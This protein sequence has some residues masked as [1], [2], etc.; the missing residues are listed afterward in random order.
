[1]RN[2]GSQLDLPG[3]EG[4]GAPEPA[5]GPSLPDWGRLVLG[6]VWRRKALA[7][8]VFLLGVTASAVYYWL[9]TPLY[10]VETKILAQRQQTLPSI[11]RPGG[12]DEA[13]TRSAHELVHR[14]ENLIN[15]VKQTNLFVG[16]GTATSKSWLE[17][18]TSPST[19]PSRE[20]EDPLNAL[21]LELDRA[22]VVTT[23]EGVITIEIDWPDPQQAYHLLQTAQ[24]NFL[25]ARHLQEITV[26]DDVISLLRGRAATLAADLQK[27]IEEVQLGVVRGGDGSP[28]SAAPRAGTSEDLAQLRA[29]IDAKERAILDVEEF[30][31]RRLAD[32]QAQLDEKRGVYSDAY[33]SV[34]SLRQDIEALTGESPQAAR[35]REDERKLR[36]EYAA[37]LGEAGQLRAPA[38]LAP[39]PRRGTDAS[40]EQNERVREAR[41][42]YQQMLERVNVAQLELDTA[43]AGFKYRYT[44]VWP[45]EVPTKTSSPRPLKTFGLGMIV[46]LLLALVAAVAPDLRS[47]RVV[48][49]W[50]VERTL[51]LPVLAEVNPK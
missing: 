1:M 19:S 12:P 5:P 2:Y 26:I 45:A 35:L 27:V 41:L 31:R 11:V 15:L 30:R 44:I 10:H 17:R 16:P 38:P 21:V 9:R 14:R 37:R 40:L 43:R 29:K 33:P 22:L 23:A 46:S 50:Q 20:D 49:R 25:E 42:Q 6:A 18:I 51:D 13:P 36:A 32:L 34:V 3:Y 39:A 4:D 8:A 47:G 24:E 7:A 48:E 28:R